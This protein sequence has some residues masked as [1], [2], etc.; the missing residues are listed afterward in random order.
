LTRSVE[1]RATGLMTD[2]GQIRFVIYRMQDG[3]PLAGKITSAWEG[4]LEDTGQGDDVVRH[5]QE[6][7]G[8]W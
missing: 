4:I 1:L 5:S 8:G 3:Q 6:L 7:R 2:R